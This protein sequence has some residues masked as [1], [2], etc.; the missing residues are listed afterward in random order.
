MPSLRGH[1]TGKQGETDG[2]RPAVGR[3][4]HQRIGQAGVARK[5][6]PA[7][8]PRDVEIDPGGEWWGRAF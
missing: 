1:V 7:E 8:A 3:S 4:T 5:A 6:S 2:V